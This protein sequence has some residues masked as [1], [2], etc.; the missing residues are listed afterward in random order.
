EQFGAEILENEQTGVTVGMD[1][2]GRGKSVLAQRIRHG[3]ERRDVFGQVRDGAVRLAVA[4]WRPIRAARRIHQDVTL[5]VEQ[6]PFVGTR[7]GVALD[8]SAGGFAEAGRV[9]EVAQ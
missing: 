2:G 3:D 6:Q 9:D 8:V 1:D 7:R 4:Y 5:A